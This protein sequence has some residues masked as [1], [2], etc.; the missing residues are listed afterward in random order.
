MID[1]DAIVEKEIDRILT[2]YRESPNMIATFRAYLHEYAEIMKYINEIPDYFDILTAIGDQLTLIGK[3]LGFPR[4]HCICTTV[5]VIGFEC[6]TGIQS[7]YQIVG[8]CEGGQW[9]ACH[10]TGTM[11]VCIGDDEIYRKMLLARRYQMLGFYDLKSLQ[12]A[13]QIVWGSQAIVVNLGGGRVCLVPARELSTYELQIEQINIRSLPIAP[14]IRAYISR[15][16]GPIAGFGDGFGG[17]CPDSTGEEPA[18][19]LCPV[20]PLT[21]DCV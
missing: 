21:Y 4:C 9:L 13:V 20:D 6:G 8:F 19:W 10:P 2:Q 3:R 17:F 12:D 7:H 15:S 18:E 5:P 14:G 11:D 1:S 16:I